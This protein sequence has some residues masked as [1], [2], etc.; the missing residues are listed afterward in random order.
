M[1]CPVIA[2]SSL[3]AFLLL[4]FLSFDLLAETLFVFAFYSLPPRDVLEGFIFQ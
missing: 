3:L 1:L 4:T 2:L